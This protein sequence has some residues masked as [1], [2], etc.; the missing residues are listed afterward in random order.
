MAPKPAHYPPVLVASLACPTSENGHIP[1]A[2]WLVY[3][4][5]ERGDTGI[6]RFSL[7]RGDEFVYRSSTLRDVMN[8]AS[9]SLYWHLNGG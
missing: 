3:E 9:D 2:S 4:E 6:S 5:A 8:Y 7:F 1:A